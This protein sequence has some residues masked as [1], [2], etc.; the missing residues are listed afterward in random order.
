MEHRGRIFIFGT[1]IHART[2]ALPPL[3]PVL[4][5]LFPD[6]RFAPGFISFPRGVKKKKKEKTDI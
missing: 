1:V 6:E 5:P 3:P 2:I 4:A